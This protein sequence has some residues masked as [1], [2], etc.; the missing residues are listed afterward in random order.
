MDNITLVFASGVFGAYA[1]IRFCDHVL[2]PWVERRLKASKA[3][4]N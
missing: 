2:G 3:E 4:G 1:W